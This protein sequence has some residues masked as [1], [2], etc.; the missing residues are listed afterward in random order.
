MLIDVGKLYLKSII[1]LFFS[2]IIIIVSDPA[3]DC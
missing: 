3:I 2:S 1:F